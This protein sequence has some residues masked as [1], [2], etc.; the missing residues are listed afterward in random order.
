M[1]RIL[2]S[3]TIYNE[4]KKIQLKEATENN[5]WIPITRM[6]DIEI[7]LKPKK[8]KDDFFEY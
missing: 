2:V 6:K 5:K 8:G 3:N 7:R 1:K 4:L